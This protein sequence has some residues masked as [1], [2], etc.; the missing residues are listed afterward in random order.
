MPAKKSPPK[1]LPLEDGTKNAAA[2][3]MVGSILRALAGPK[4][5]RVGEPVVHRIA[6][7]YCGQINDLNR[8]IKRNLVPSEPRKNAKV[9]RPEPGGNPAD[10]A[11]LEEAFPV[12]TQEDLERLIQSLLESVH[13]H[14]ELVALRMIEHRRDVIHDSRRLLQL[15]RD[16]DGVHDEELASALWRV[17]VLLSANGRGGSTDALD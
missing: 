15:V 14:W 5:L 12:T 17:Q 2:S 3:V 8:R 13:P 10:L 16:I 6:Q 4:K 7:L 11:E 9:K 1:V